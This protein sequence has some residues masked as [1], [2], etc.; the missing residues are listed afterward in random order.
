MTK[1]KFLVSVVNI[2]FR[3]DKRHLP[4]NVDVSCSIEGVLISLR[5]IL[6]S[7]LAERRAASSGGGGAAQP[8]D[9]QGEGRLRQHQTGGCSVP[10]PTPSDTQPSWT[11][12]WESCLFRLRIT[13]VEGIS[14]WCT[15]NTTRNTMRL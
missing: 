9:G 6:M 15:H 13:C 12:I 11:R 2:Q 4:Y 10:V 14:E 7:C 5:I 3:I 1:G 8:A